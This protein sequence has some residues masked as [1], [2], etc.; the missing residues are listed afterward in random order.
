MARGVLPP[1]SKLVWQSA[2]AIASQRYTCGFC[3]H[4]IASERGWAAHSP[5][6]GKEAAY[7]VICHFCSR[8]TFIDEKLRQFPGPSFGDPV[9]GVDDKAVAA[10]YDEARNAVSA[11]SFTAAVLCCRKLLMHIAVTKGAPVNRTFV[12]Y[13]EYLASNGYIPPDAKPWVDHIRTKSNEANHEIVIMAKDDAVELL[14][15]SEMLLKVIF[16]FPSR[17]R[18]KGGPLPPAT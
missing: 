14:S 8:A 15:F 18:K 9:E 17:I 5:Y 3:G 10:L 7:V 4:E 6:D 11:G 16:E 2:T 12:T 1:G 13:V